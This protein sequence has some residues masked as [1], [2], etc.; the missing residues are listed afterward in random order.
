MT[1]TP[2]LQGESTSDTPSQSTSPDLNAVAYPFT[3]PRHA[4]SGM[5]GCGRPLRARASRSVQ[6]VGDVAPR[7]DTAAAA[8]LQDA[9][10]GGVG[11]RA[12]LGAGAVGDPPGD[13]GVT[14]GA[15]GLV[16]GGG[17][18][19]VGDEGGDCR[20]VVEDLAGERP[21]LLGL[22]IAVELAGALQPGE[23]RIDDARTGALGNLVDQ[24]AHLAQQ[25]RPDVGALGVEA[26]GQRYSL[27]DQMGQTSLALLGSDG[28]DIS[29]PSWIRWAR[30]LWPFLNLR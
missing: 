18:I 17:Q 25:P 1:D 10:S 29:G 11:R 20:P 21:N 8:G 15:L 22:V 7:F 6:Q 26:T 13:D 14:Q 3:S 28:P 19:G 30:H 23:H 12:L 9:Q 5:V 16:V 24:A 4:E 27:A 2:D